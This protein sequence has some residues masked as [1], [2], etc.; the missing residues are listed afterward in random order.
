L[1][2]IRAEDVPAGIDAG[3]HAAGMASSLANLAAHLRG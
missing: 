1:V 3:D 2:E